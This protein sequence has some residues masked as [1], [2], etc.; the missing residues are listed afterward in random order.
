MQAAATGT[1]AILI[2]FNQTYGIL[3]VTISYLLIFLSTTGPCSFAFITEICT[4]IAL[5]IAMS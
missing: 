5:G 1:L 4:D 3:V 2:Q